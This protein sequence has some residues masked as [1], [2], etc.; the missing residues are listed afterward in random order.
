MGGAAFFLIV[1]WGGGQ[2]ATATA[3]TISPASGSGYVGSASPA[4]T[5]APNATLNSNETVT[6]S[7]SASGTFTPSSLSFLSG[8]ASGQTFTYTPSAAGTFTLTATPAPSLGVPPT[9]TY[10]ATLAPVPVVIV[11]PVVVIVPPP[12]IVDDDTLQAIISLWV[13]AT[14]TT[15]S[16]MVDDD[17]LTAIRNFWRQA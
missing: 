11:P 17:T 7:D 12:V 4:F 5:V 10:T 1:L 13:G 2:P 9:A 6:L 8:S 3:F 14:I 15:P 16:V